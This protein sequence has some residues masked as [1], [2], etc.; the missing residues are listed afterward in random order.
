MKKTQ[1]INVCPINV[2]LT[3]RALAGRDT[4]V[5]LLAQELE[6]STGRETVTV[7]FAEG[8]KDALYH[9]NPTV[10]LTKAELAEFVVDRSHS[11]S[12]PGPSLEVATATPTIRALVDGVGWDTAKQFAE[13]RRLLQRMGTESGREIHGVHVLDTRILEIKASHYAAGRPSPNFIITNARFANEIK[14]ARNIGATLVEIRRPA[15]VELDENLKSH[16][17]ETL[18][19]TPDIV[20]FN[21]G[22]INDSD[23]SDSE[24]DNLRDVAVEVHRRVMVD[25]LC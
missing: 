21:N 12:G 16:A 10:V 4:F 7:A 15:G 8:V 6:R 23:L 11:K 20:V 2:C 19:T 9:L 14:Y 3:G 22:D 24:L 17:S 13:V 1:P 25:H 5:T 18:A